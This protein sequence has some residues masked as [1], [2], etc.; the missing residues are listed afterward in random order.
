L[1]QIK[2]IIFIVFTH[3][4]LQARPI[5]SSEQCRRET[6]KHIPA[7]TITVERLTLNIAKSRG[8]NLVSVQAFASADASAI[9][10]KR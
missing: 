5:Y 3:A 8:R 2:D 6:L 7:S 10:M 1:S 4:H 9:T